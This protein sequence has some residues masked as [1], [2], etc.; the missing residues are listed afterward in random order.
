MSLWPPHCF[1]LPP[2]LLTAS[3]QLF[4]VKNVPPSELKTSIACIGVLA[5][6]RI[7][8]THVC[9]ASA[10]GQCGTYGAALQEW[11]GLEKRHSLDL[12]AQLQINQNL[13]P[14]LASDFL[15]NYWGLWLLLWSHQGEPCKCPQTQASWWTFDC[16]YTASANLASIRSTS[17]LGIT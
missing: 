5:T 14:T 15:S 17:K 7:P 9:S 13:I 10:K 2:Y 6:L 16:A 12:I 4:A 3:L 11:A 1:T 8:K